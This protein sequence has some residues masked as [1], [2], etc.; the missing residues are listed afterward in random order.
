[1]VGGGAMMAGHL[2]MTPIIGWD[3][4]SYVSN[5]PLNRTVNDMEGSGMLSSFD[6]NY[7]NAAQ[8]LF[9]PS[10]YHD[11]VLSLTAGGRNDILGLNFDYYSNDLRDPNEVGLRGWFNYNKTINTVIGINTA[12]NAGAFAYNNSLINN[13]TSQVMAQQQ[14][15]AAAA[16]AP[17]AAA[18]SSGTSDNTTLSSFSSGTTSS[19]IAS[20]QGTVGASMLLAAP[21][22]SIAY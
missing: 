3:G 22:I 21:G 16:Q 14:A 12:M 7:G 8:Y 15:A 5:R 6:R 11:S 13:T 4:N 18:S 2:T 9:D 19:S 10:S 1:M 20:S 17:A